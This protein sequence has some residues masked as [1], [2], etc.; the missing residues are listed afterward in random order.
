MGPDGHT[1]SL[2]PGHPLVGEVSG[3]RVAAISDSPKPPPTR[4]TLTLPV[5]LSADHVAFI[6]TGDSKADLMPGILAGNVDQLPAGMVRPTSGNL[7][8]FLDSD[9]AAKL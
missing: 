6:A 3:K 8:W 2:F 1:A 7:T 9:A 5:L 4:I